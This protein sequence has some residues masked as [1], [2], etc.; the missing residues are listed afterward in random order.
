M[1]TAIVM[2]CP[3]P[4]LRGDDMEKSQNYLLFTYL[5][6]LTWGI[7]LKF[8]LYLPWPMMY[9]SLNMIPY[10]ELARSVDGHSIDWRE[11]VFNIVSFI[12]LG[13]FLRHGRA[14]KVLGLALG[15]SVFYEGVQYL[16]AIGMADI[17]DVIH[18]TLGAYAGF[19]LGHG[20]EKLW[21]CITNDKENRRV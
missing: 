16:L 17:T 18:N 2:V 8:H 11:I 6:V 5:A 9:R 21:R 4:F 13:M 3:T 14:T 20:M 19:R 12:P 7:L 1:G 15:L 10:A